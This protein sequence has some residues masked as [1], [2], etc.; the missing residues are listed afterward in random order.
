[1]IVIYTEVTAFTDVV[2]PITER[3]DSGNKHQVM[4]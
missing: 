1:M 3:K 2:G 4:E